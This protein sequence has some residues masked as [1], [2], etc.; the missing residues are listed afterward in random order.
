MNDVPP[1]PSKPRGLRVVKA[2]PQPGEVRRWACWLDDDFLGYA[3]R[4]AGYGTSPWRI[5]P[6]PGLGMVLGGRFRTRRDAEREL[7]WRRTP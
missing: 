7:L 6:V 5:Q 3:V 1:R 2:P 4:R